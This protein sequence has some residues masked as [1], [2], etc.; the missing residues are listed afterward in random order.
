MDFT[1]HYC[2]NCQFNDEELSHGCDIF[3]RALVFKIADPEY[4]VEWQ[5]D[6]GGAFCTSFQEVGVEPV[7]P[8]CRDTIDLFDQIEGVA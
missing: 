2:A 7:L 5:Q 3:T 4:P 8:R 1:A 6:D